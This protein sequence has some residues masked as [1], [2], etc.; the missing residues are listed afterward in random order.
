M[1]GLPDLLLNAL[2]Y[3]GSFLFIAASEDECRKFI[4]ACLLYFE[5]YIEDVSEDGMAITTENGSVIC[6]VS[7][8][9]LD[10][11]FFEDRVYD[12]FL[13]TTKLF[14]YQL[15]LIAESKL[16]ALRSRGRSLVDVMLEYNPDPSTYH[17]LLRKTTIDPDEGVY[18]S[19]LMDEWRGL[20][21]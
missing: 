14:R 4:D 17:D 13:G 6:A 20:Q 5:D 18:S 12:D 3:K 16:A 15:E 9:Q 10:E 11:E 19:R 1:I 7:S 2:E 8:E 21:R